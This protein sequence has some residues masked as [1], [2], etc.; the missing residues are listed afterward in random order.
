MLPT[1][2]AALT[3]PE[4]PALLAVDMPIGFAEIA[5]KGG[6]ECERAA[7]KLLPGKT[8]SVFSIPCRMALPA[9]T[10][11]EASAL[12]AASGN[13]IRVAIQAFHLLPKLRELDELITPQLQNQ[14]VE[15]HPELAFALM[16]E[17]QPVLSKKSRSAGRRDRRQL[18]ERHGLDV[19]E[20][21][22]V[23]KGVGIDDALDA[24]ALTVTAERVFLKQAICMPDKPPRDARGLRMEIWY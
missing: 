14:L 6:R 17:G 7:R 8:S 24:I 16:N 10:H 5:V 18:L 15:A 1:I 9:G 20:L 19:P 21:L 12:N 23:S 22:K 11:A 2:A 4:K 3:L 13:G